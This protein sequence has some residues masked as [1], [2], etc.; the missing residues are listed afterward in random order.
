MP[1]PIDMLSRQLGVMNDVA[2]LGSGQLGGLFGKKGP[3]PDV[4]RAHTG[5]G[6]SAEGWPTEFADEDEGYRMAQ[7]YVARASFRHP[8]STGE[9]SWVGG[10]ADRG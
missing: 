4:R 5:P 10:G 3:D 1:S 8:A 2:R 7:A 9:A 6:I